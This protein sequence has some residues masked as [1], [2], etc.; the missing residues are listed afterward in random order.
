LEAVLPFN[1][2]TPD[3]YRVPD[4]GWGPD[5]PNGVYLPSMPVILEIV[6]PGDDT[7]E[8]FDFYADHGVEEIIVVDRVAQTV[9][10]WVRSFRIYRPVDRSTALGISTAELQAGIRWPRQEKNK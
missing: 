3:D 1:I 5:I 6:S 9:E 4:A 7:F 8:K 10:I 2:G